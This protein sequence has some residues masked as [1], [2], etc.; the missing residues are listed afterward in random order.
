MTWD[1]PAY[2]AS[3]DSNSIG[4]DGTNDSEYFLMNPLHTIS[5][6][7]KNTLSPYATDA[8]VAHTYECIDEIK[9]SASVFACNN[10]E[11]HEPHPSA[12]LPPDL[13]PG[14]PDG[15]RGYVK[16]ET[17]G[18]QYEALEKPRHIENQNCK[19]PEDQYET[20]EKPIHTQSQNCR[21]VPGDHHEK[22][23]AG[24]QYEILEKPR[25]TQNQNC[26][27]PGDQY[28]TL[29][30]VIHTQSQ[31]CWSIVRDQYETLEQP[32]HNQSQNN[33]EPQPC[34]SRLVTL[35]LSRDVS[36]IESVVL[37]DNCQYANSETQDTVQS[38]IQNCPPQ[39]CEDIV[40][41]ASGRKDCGEPDIPHPYASLESPASQ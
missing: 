16:P 3:S 8:D 37:D 2:G 19:S 5:T 14:I 10:A 4:L 33:Q 20:L 26:K 23:R 1:S 7:G 13:V 30:K 32:R 34:E 11:V 12:L 36:K 25:H 6:S 39:G 15:E 9:T 35:T 24:D 22:T 40:V 38:Q 28:E 41:L 21:P 17:P 31:N 29:E 27:S 18:D